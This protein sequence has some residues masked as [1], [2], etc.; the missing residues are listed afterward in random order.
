MGVHLSHFLASHFLGN[1][2]LYSTASQNVMGLEYH[3]LQIVLTYIAH[4]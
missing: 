2:L 1:I 3:L 4:V